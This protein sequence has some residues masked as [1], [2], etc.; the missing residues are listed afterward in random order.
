MDFLNN[1]VYGVPLVLLVALWWM[2]M[3]ITQFKGNN[4]NSNNVQNT[5][6]N[7]P[8]SRKGKT[9]YRVECINCKSE[10]NAKSTKCFYCGEIQN[11]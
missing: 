7:S 8:F 1:T 4:S 2:T 10:I 6:G 9:K 5:K 11:K 3:M